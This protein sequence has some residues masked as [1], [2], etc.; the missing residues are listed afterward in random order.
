[1]KVKYLIISSIILVV[2]AVT[3][4]ALY[5]AW[6]A[7][8]GTITNNSYFTSEDMQESYDNG[9]NDGCSN[10][11]ELTGQVD[12]YKEL[13]DTY[14]K[15]IL[16]YKTANTNLQ[17]SLDSMKE[18]K[19]NLE[20]Q[21]ENLTNTNNLNQETI[22]DLN[23]EKDYLESQI[24]ELQ[25]IKANNERTIVEK[26][27]KIKD[28][29]NE[30]ASLENNNS[31]NI[32]EIANLRSE[33][34]SLENEIAILK[35]D[36]LNKDNQIS[37][38]SSQVK[39][40]Q[41]LNSQLQ[42]T[43]ELNLQTINN[44][45]NQITSLNT[46]I[47]DMT[48]QIQNNSTT[49]SS[50]NNKIAE[51]EKSIAYYEQYIAGLESENQVVATFEFNGSVYNIQ[52][53]EKN[54]N[55]TVTTPTSTDY[56]IFN[57]W[58]VDGEQVDLSTYQVSANTTF[59]ADVT[60]KYDVKYMVDG[61]IWN[62][63]IVTKDNYSSV[64]TEPDKYDYDFD[65]W[66]INGVDI[67]NPETIQITSNTT[68]IAKYTKRHYVT[69]ILDG[70]ELTFRYVRNNELAPNVVVE[71]NTYRVFNGW[72]LNGVIV[73]MSTTKIVAD[74]TF[75][76]DCTYFYDVNFVVDNSVINSQIVIQNGY[77][78][79]PS[80][81]IKDGYAFD[82]WTIDGSTL[83][84]PNTIAVTSNLTFVAQFT[85][86]HTVTFVYEDTT[87]STQTIRHNE[88]ANNVNAQNTTY[89]VFNGWSVNGSI[90]SINNYPITSDTTFVADVTYKYDVN[91]YVD[92]TLYNNQVVTAGGYVTEPDIPE[93]NGF[94]FVGWS[95]NNIDVIN[96][97]EIVINENITLYG[98][99][100]SLAGS[101][102]YET[103]E[104][105]MSWD[106]L[107][108]NNIFTVSDT[109]VL[110]TGDNYT[111]FS[112]TSLILPEGITDIN[113]KYLSNSSASYSTTCY[114]FQSLKSITLP[115]SLVSISGKV[116]DY[117]NN[118]TLLEVHIPSINIS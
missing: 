100:K 103:G 3:G 90:V 45:N 63:Q 35:T 22:N 26:E 54:G 19:S 97:N 81:P 43:N 24:K 40:L 12:Y 82:G 64:P 77:A 75:V 96:V 8:T 48:L 36:N 6:P 99:F 89:K 95:L 114:V 17:T 53:L 91:F 106:D 33:I 116:V 65:G 31:N 117:N 83:V 23:D 56:V 67:V 47:S 60:Y 61:N 34:A 58:T 86:L 5:C 18:Q 39:S 37:S 113:Y 70:Q 1:M 84:T 107:I 73:D 2:M 118:K 108:S 71:S 15:Q 115:S 49:V 9:F 101:F 20:V 74:T 87:L 109:G 13:T 104:L 30:I 42:K 52:I 79:T 98:L 28:L 78:T 50:L 69:Y 25:I 94:S 62:T 85:Q 7:I 55:V 92:G 46:Q 51:L 68:F 72:S 105:V 57:Y 76:A 93:K 16:D 80:N 21:V 41:N 112:G 102:D 27:A 66:T 38:L 10:F 4:I 111:T 44:L 11:D 59:V 110:N 29:E 14:Y 88:Y 32:A